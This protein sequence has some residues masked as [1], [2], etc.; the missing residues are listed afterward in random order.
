MGDEFVPEFSDNL[1]AS[2]S[3]NFLI[4]RVGLRLGMELQ[5]GGVARARGRCCLDAA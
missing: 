2:T 1:K 5:N 4:G 3:K